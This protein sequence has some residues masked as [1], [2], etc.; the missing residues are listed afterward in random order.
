MTLKHDACSGP[1]SDAEV[2]R[3]VSSLG[4]LP[5]RLHYYDDYSKVQ[6]ELTD[7]RR[8]GIWS[9]VSD[10]KRLRFD[11]SRHSAA[12]GLLLKHWALKELARTKATSAYSCLRGIQGIAERLGIELF[13]TVLGAHPMELRAYWYARIYSS[14]GQSDA[15]G[16]KSLLHFCCEQSLGQLSPDHIDFSS[17]LALPTRDKYAAVRNG[18]VFLTLHEEAVLFDYLTDLASLLKKD[19]IACPLR[20]VRQAAFLALALQWGLRP[21]MIALIRDQDVRV[22]IDADG[23]HSAV[24]VVEAIKRAKDAIV[25]TATRSCRTEWAPIITAYARRRDRPEEQFSRGLEDHT[26]A[27]GSFF[28]AAATTISHDIA[29]LTGSLLSKPRTATDLRHAG[30]QRLADAGASREDLRRYLFHEEGSDTALVYI[31]Q[32]PTQASK[33]NQALALSPIYTAIVE[34]AKSR[35]IDKAK[36]PGLAPDHQIGGCPHGVPIAGIGA[37]EVGQ[38]LCSRNPVLSCYACTKFMP[39]A[40]VRLHEQVRDS[41]RG[42]VVE[43]FH[44]S[45]DDSSLPPAFAQLSRTI[46]AVDAT[47]AALSSSEARL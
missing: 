3:A 17:R 25:E 37:C 43:S 1:E 8:S 13:S 34:I 30:A 41:L 32:S 33:L 39:V 2:L 47:I 38:S 7:L 21:M 16:L 10:G 15:R 19:P 11:F 5:D 9:V 31:D 29:E 12:V 20:G 18:S 14:F 42:I 46:A 24:F 36:L 27:P 4:P 28:R 35:V 40:D 6:R 45:L 26:I 23:A 22:S 44:A